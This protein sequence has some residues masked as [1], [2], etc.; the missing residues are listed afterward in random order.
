MAQAILNLLKSITDVDQL[1]VALV[2]MVPLIELKGAI[3]IGEGLGLPIY[4]TALIA[5]F[6]STLIIIPIFFL[7]IPIFNLLKKIPFIKK[8]VEKLEAM[9]RSRAEKVA[10]NI[11]GSADERQRQFLVRAL[12]IFVAI[13]LPL[14][15]VWTGAAI[16]VFLNMRFKDSVIPLALGNFIAGSIVTLLTYLFHDY[17]DYIITGMFLIALIMLAVAIIRIITAKPKADSNGQEK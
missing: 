5:Y 16:A 4:E 13:P 7:L 12:L 6:G 10:A 14:T 3:P 2:S 11:G 15:G 9:L 1:I 17:V 8:F